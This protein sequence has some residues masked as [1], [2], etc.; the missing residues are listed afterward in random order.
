MENKNEVKNRQILI[1]TDGVSI[2]LIKAEATS[3][4]ELKAI[5]NAMIDFTN[6]Q[7]NLAADEAKRK[8]SLAKTEKV[9]ETETKKEETPEVK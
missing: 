2:Q 7:I 9:V 3:L 4:I 5:F 1:E 6:N 8:A